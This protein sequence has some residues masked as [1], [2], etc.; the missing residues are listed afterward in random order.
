MPP[1]PV[2]AHGLNRPPPCC[3]LQL[4]PNLYW[5]MEHSDKS[6]RRYKKLGI[7]PPAAVG[8]LPPNDWNISWHHSYGSDYATKNQCHEHGRIPT[9][10]SAAGAVVSGFFKRRAAGPLPVCNG[11]A[12]SSCLL[13]SAPPSRRPAGSVVSSSTRLR[14]SQSA[15]F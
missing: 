14:Q 9:S 15:L 13:R 8:G 12:R 4:A 10:Y 5:F 7:T 2:A 3:A 6:E 11:A 1:L